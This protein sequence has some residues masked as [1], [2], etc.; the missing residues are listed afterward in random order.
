MRPH[1]WDKRHTLACPTF[2][3]EMESW[4][5]FLPGLAWNHDLP[6]LNLQVARIT[7]VS[8]QHLAL[9]LLFL[10]S[11]FQHK[12]AQIGLELTH[13][14]P[15]STLRVLRLQHVPPHPALNFMIFTCRYP[16]FQW[17]FDEKTIIFPLNGH[18]ILCSSFCLFYASTILLITMDLQRIF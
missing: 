8:H 5:H 14:P 15:V 16:I 9:L 13:D 3:I 11:F 18:D 2:P 10:C 17:P 12:V 7:T 1:S 4:E 6:Y